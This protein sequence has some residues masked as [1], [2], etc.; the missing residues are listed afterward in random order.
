MVTKTT[1]TSK[2]SDGPKRGRCAR[3]EET[4]G[5]FW[6]F[7]G[8]GCRPCRSGAP[9]NVNAVG[10]FLMVTLPSWLTFSTRK[11]SSISVRFRVPIAMNGL[12]P[13]SRK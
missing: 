11:P 13:V 9:R 5:F 10:Y 12:V 7:E 4:P 6:D 3:L 2:T 1:T 8:S